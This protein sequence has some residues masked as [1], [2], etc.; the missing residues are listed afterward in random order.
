M[1]LRTFSANGG[2]MASYERAYTTDL[3]VAHTAERTRQRRDRTI[4]HRRIAQ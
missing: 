2:A 1:S 4:V 3:T